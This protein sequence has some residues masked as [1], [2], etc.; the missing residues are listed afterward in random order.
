MRVHAHWPLDRRF[1]H[2]DSCFVAFL[3]FSNKSQEEIHRMQ[4][5]KSFNS[6]FRFNISIK[7]F[8]QAKNCT[9][10]EENSAM[11]SFEFC[12]YFLFLHGQKLVAGKIV[13]IVRLWNPV[14]FANTKCNIH[15]VVVKFQ[16]VHKTCTFTT[17]KWNTLK[18]WTTLLNENCVSLNGHTHSDSKFQ[19]TFFLVVAGWHAKMCAFDF[20]S[21]HSITSWINKMKQLSICQSLT[22]Q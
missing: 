3:Y 10:Q 17:T 8:V 16:N 6:C 9:C 18:C 1:G 12:F 15:G 14:I 7:V 5:K 22:T 20:R 11:F 19:F 4:E 21:K 13:F 2:F